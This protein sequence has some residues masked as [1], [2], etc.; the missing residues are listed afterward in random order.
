MQPDADTT[1]QVDTMPV[2]TS[3]DLGKIVQY[4]GTTTTTEPIY[5]NGYFYEVVEDTSTTPSTYKWVAKQ[6]QAG[7]GSGG[8][9]LGKDITAAIDVGGIDTGD[10][11]LTGT[12]YDD[13]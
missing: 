13:M 5:T 7:G 1:I 3:T 9:S 10:S 11:F 4:V 2:V 8:G 12:S 6:V